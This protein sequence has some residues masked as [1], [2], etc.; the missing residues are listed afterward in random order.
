MFRRLF[1]NVGISVE[2]MKILQNLGG[3]TNMGLESFSVNFGMEMSIFT[4]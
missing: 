3:I 1:N 4:C 2:Y